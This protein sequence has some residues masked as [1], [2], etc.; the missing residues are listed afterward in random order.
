MCAHGK[1]RVSCNEQQQLVLPSAGR[2][3][4]VLRAVVRAALPAALGLPAAGRA[5][6][7]SP[8]PV[9]SVP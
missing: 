8:A 9:A 4:A 7:A 6:P 3:G 2:R 1:Q 5:L